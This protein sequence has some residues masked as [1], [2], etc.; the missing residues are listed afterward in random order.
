MVDLA[1]DLDPARLGAAHGVDRARRLHVHQVHV[2]AAGLGEADQHVAG[3]V[4]DHALAGGVGLRVGLRGVLPAREEVALDVVHQRL[5]VRV[6]HER[7]PGGRDQV[8]RLQQVAVVVH[9]R[10]RRV[11]VRAA[12]VDDHEDLVG[13]DA[14][15]G[16]RHDLVRVGG[17]RVVV[18]VDDRLLGVQRQ[19]LVEQLGARGRRLQVGHPE[20]RRH[21]AGGRGQAGGGDVLL[22]REARLA[23]VHVRVDH[24]GQ[25]QTIGR[26][27]RAADVR[28]LER[29]ADDARDPAV[30]DEHVGVPA[31]AG[32]DDLAACDPQI[33][34]HV[35]RSSLSSMVSGRPSP[36]LTTTPPLRRCV[37]NQSTISGVTVVQ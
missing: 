18:V 13:A 6:D 25:N 16:H 2:A 9:A 5:V 34:P 14:A 10:A 21:A 15:L 36:L 23:R 19:D 12:G 31:P 8:H 24:A 26:V 27:D 32:Q 11:R 7:Q 29:R 20:D 28:E 37:S 33:D 17:R 3:G 30:L 35:Q 4:P 22:V 1:G